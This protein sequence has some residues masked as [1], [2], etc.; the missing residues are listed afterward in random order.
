[1]FTKEG[2]NIYKTTSHVESVHLYAQPCDAVQVQIQIQ[3]TK[4]F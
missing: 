3:M 1:M 4:H 2:K